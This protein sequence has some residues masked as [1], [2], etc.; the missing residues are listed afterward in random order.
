MESQAAQKLERQLA[1]VERKRKRLLLASGVQI[2]FGPPCAFW[3]LYTD[4]LA[5][6]SR[7]VLSSVLAGVGLLWTV[8]GCVGLY[9]VTARRVQALVVFTSLEIFLAVLT[10]SATA[11]LLLLHHVNCWTAPNTPAA[12]AQNTA[13]STRVASVDLPQPWMRC[14]NV[15]WLLA[16]S[17]MM[18]LYLSATAFEAPPPPLG[19]A[20]RRLA[21]A[22]IR[23]TSVS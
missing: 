16:A 18:V 22:S 2:L 13:N 4:P 21:P 3:T 19:G 7:S 23:A 9:A 6:D 15:A 17:A 11:V 20:P 1:K 5:V 14:A 12:D 10:S 8:A